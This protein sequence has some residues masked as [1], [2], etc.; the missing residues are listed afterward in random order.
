MQPTCLKATLNS[1]AQD[2]QHYHK[3][4]T[5]AN[6]HTQFLASSTY[7]LLL[8]VELNKS[9][10]KVATFVTASAAPIFVRSSATAESTMRTMSSAERTMRRLLQAS[11]TLDHTREELKCIVDKRIASVCLQRFDDK[12]DTAVLPAGMCVPACQT[13]T[14]RHEIHI[15]TDVVVVEADESPRIHD[16]DQVVS[17]AT[18]RQ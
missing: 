12:L 10:S 15:S 3:S 5:H 18:Q 9:H 6:K 11:L 7:D 16:L 8:L 13:I 1:P 14:I 17:R 2:A 4:L